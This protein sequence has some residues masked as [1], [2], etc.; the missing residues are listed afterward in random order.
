[1]VS[2]WDY[3]PGA[4]PGHPLGGVAAR[5]ALEGVGAT[6]PDATDPTPASVELTVRTAYY[7]SPYTGQGRI[8]VTRGNGSTTSRPLDHG[9]ADPHAAALREV[10]P[11]AA[12]ILRLTDPPQGAARQGR[13]YAVTVAAVPTADR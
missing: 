13:R 8:R 1:M 7:A 3:S 6:L 9:A 12:S 11:Y 10:Y 2:R 5:Y 4:V